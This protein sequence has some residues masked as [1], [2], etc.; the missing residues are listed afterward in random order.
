M[1]KLEEKLHEIY[2]IDSDVVGLKC[3]ALAA[4]EPDVALKWEPIQQKR[5]PWP[6]P[7]APG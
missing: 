2:L 4:R 7:P 5:E 6:M 3:V 1:E